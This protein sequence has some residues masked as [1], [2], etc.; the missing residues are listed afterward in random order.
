MF[1][2]LRFRLPAIFLA[3]V[4]R[5]GLVSSL[6]AIRLFQDHV[7]KESLAELRREAIGIA[8]LYAEKAGDIEIA[9]ESL[10]RATG[11]RLF[12]IGL[13]LFPG[14]QARPT[15]LPVAAVAAEALG[16]AVRAP[17]T[18]VPRWDRGRR[19]ARVV[20]LAKDHEAGARAVCGRRPGRG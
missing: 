8:Q 11:D 9:P 17:R 1:R 20:P 19:R 7:R 2:S 14:Q 16:D 5:A 18:G 12:Y 15:Q 3:G 10:E 4:A 13:D 6:I